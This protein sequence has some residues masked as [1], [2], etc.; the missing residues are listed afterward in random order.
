[1]LDC[2]RGKP[3]VNAQLVDSSILG[4]ISLARVS[5]K[6]CGD[7]L[8]LLGQLR[9]HLTA[10][11]NSDAVM[12]DWQRQRA[13]ELLKFSQETIKGAY[14]KIGKKTVAELDG[15]SN[16]EVQKLT[17]TVN[18]VVGVDISTKMA[19]QQLE[20]IAKTD[21]LLAQGATQSDWWSKQG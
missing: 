5:K 21:K 7:V 1:M 14:E 6:I 17:T 12:T 3:T 13:A 20:A 15:L 19:P 11:L 10:K 18:A 4:G 16:V 9:D 8:G 2:A